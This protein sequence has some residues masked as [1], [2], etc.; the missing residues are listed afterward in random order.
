VEPLIDPAQRFLSTDGLRLARFELI[1]TRGDFGFPGLRGIGIRRPIQ[2]REKTVSQ[3]GTLLRR[4]LEREIEGGPSFAANVEATMGSVQS[5]P[6]AQW[7][8]DVDDVD[9]VAP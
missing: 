6:R 3:S 7:A 4:E 9:A 5:G 8:T 2:A 1:E